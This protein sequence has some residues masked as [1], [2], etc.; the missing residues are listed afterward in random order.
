MEASRAADA[1]GMLPGHNIDVADAD[2]AYTQSY[3]EG[4]VQTWVSIPREQWPQEW[5]DLG[6]HDPVC[7]LVLSLYGHPDA[8]GAL[9][10]SLRQGYPVRGL[11][12]DSRLALLLLARRMRI[13][14]HSLRRRL[15]DGRAGE[16][17]ETALVRT[18]W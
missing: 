6:Y 4:P 10:T 1:Y 17:Q 18:H 15:Q 9:G 12:T 5:F 13:L 16:T 14:P 8:G 2:Q 7:P 11:G 3:L